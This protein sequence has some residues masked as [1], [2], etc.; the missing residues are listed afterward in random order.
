MNPLTVTWAP[1]IYT[2]IGFENYVNM[3]NSGFDG[4]VGWPDGILHRKLSRI[5]FELKGDPF[6]PFVYGQKSFAFHISVNFNI[7]L[8]FYGENGEVEYGGSMKN[9]NKPFE[10]VDNWK[11]SYFK[12]SGVDALVAEGH[13]MGI[14]D[15]DDIKLDKYKFYKPPSED[16]IKAVGSE[17][18]W[19][20]Y[21]KMWIPQE[22]FYYCTENTGFKPNIKRTECTYTKANSIDDQIDNFHFFLAYLKFGYGRATR[23]ACS[24][25]R[26]GHITREE[27]VNLV[28]K[29]DHEFPREYFEKFLQYL[30]INEEKFWEISNR[31]R[32]KKI[33]SYDSKSSSWN[34]NIKVVNN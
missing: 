4:V 11:T 27:A 12:G 5:A 22:N 24:D 1:H 33:W 6:E 25:I 17:M 2:Q 16:K 9:E 10:T 29:Y 13:K 21:Y 23:D 30:D 34:L 3:C 18:H 20:S 15:A 7:P 19:W 28:N 14:L 8:I 31:Y 26:C 32:N